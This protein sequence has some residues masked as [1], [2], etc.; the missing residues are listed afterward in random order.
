MIAVVF[1]ARRAS[2]TSN[3]VNS[4]TRR[5]GTCATPA[6]SACGR[7]RSR[8]GETSAAVRALGDQS[9]SGNENDNSPWHDRCPDRPAPTGSKVGHGPRR[10]Y[11]P[12]GFV[13]VRETGLMWAN[14]L[15]AFQVGK[16]LASD[17]GPSSWML[18]SRMAWA[19]VRRPACHLTKASASA[20]M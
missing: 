12:A 19:Q 14:L 15:R 16:A 4:S 18:P 3:Q 9:C 20:V 8:K 11:Q 2:R 7:I 5:K 17:E 1:P 6:R 13:P 10:G